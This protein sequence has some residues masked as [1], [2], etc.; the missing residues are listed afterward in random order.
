MQSKEDSTSARDIQGW[1]FIKYLAPAL[2]NLKKKAMGTT[3]WDI[4]DGK[5]KQKKEGRF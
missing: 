3:Y 1:F 4:L 2:A 5:E